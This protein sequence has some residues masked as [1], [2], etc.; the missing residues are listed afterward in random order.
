MLSILPVSR[1]DTGR[2]TCPVPMEKM[3]YNPPHFPATHPAKFFLLF[4][5]ALPPSEQTWNILVDVLSKAFLN[6]L[7]S[8]W[9][10]LFVLHH[11]L[12]VLH[13][14]LFPALQWYPM[15]SLF[16]PAEYWDRADANKIYRHNQDPSVSGFDH[17]WRSD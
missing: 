15:P 4:H 3:E 16:L 6:F 9:P 7:K 12:K 14:M 1:K 2:S 17:N 13:T 10:F 5:A 8:G 11:N